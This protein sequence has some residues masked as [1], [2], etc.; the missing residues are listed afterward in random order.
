MF[1]TSKATPPRRTGAG[2]KVS[3]GLHDQKEKPT[4]KPIVL[5]F[6]RTIMVFGRVDEATRKYRGRSVDKA[7]DSLLAVLWAP[8]ISVMKVK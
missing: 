6:R 1:T 2:V 5:K 3:R 8:G 4:M 7:E